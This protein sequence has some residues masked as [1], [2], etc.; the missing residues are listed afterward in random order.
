MAE[1]WYPQNSLSVVFDDKV[2]I[3][4][5]FPIPNFCSSPPLYTHP[6]LRP[7]ACSGC[8]CNLKVGRMPWAPSFHLH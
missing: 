6:Q 8:L 5:M 2:L 4:P 1:L 7:S 3:L